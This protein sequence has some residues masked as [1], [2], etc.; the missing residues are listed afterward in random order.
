LRAIA[1]PEEKKNPRWTDNPPAPPPPGEGRRSTR[2]LTVGDLDVVFQPIVDLQTGRARGFEALVRCKWREYRN[3]IDLFVQAGEER[4]CGRVGRLIR[5][6]TFERG[7]GTPLFVNIHPE[8]LE[9][10]WLVR[11]DDPLC[12]H[13]DDLFLEITESA[14]FE[15]FDLCHD[16]LKEVCA[17]TGAHLAIDDLGAGFSNLERIVDLEPKIVKLDLSL[18]KGIEKNPR[19]QILIR[20]LVQLSEDLGAQVVVEGIETTDELSAVRD[21]GAHF[22][23]G[24][25]LARPSWPAPSV[26]WPVPPGTSGGF[27]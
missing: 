7:G 14:T 16:V 4:S 24:Y 15:Q 1:V 8:E 3:P 19:K 5:E 11:P 20:H 27:R 10:R 6:V 12:F 18:V 17:R 2:S 13:D 22:G 26:N 25:L 21:T 9:S 23:Q